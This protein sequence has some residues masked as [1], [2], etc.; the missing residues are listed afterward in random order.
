MCLIVFGYRTVPGYRLIFAANRD[1]FYNRP[2]ESAR[3]WPENRNMLAGKDLKAG[4]TWLGV[5]RSGRYAALTNFRNLLTHNPDA[6]SRGHL[7]TE[8][9]NSDS[10]PQ[11]FLKSLNNPESYNGFNLLA[12][13][14]NKF[15]H[16]SNRSMKITEVPPGIHSVSNAFMNTP[17]PKVTQAKKEFKTLAENDSLNEK[18]LFKLLLNKKT[19]PHD[20]LPETGLSPEMEKAVSAAFIKTENYGTRCSTILNIRDNGRVRFIERIFKPGTNEVEEEN[21]YDFSFL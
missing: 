18:N 20:Q 21:G 19:Y 6:K 16:F 3:F 10:Q 1:E 9:L 15:F 8:Y 2:T 5:H 13:D 14:K 7:V 11:D 17:W 4:G 12:G